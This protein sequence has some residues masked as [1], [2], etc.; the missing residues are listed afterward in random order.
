M[1]DT[2]PAQPARQPVENMPGMAQR[3]SLTY[4][5]QEVVIRKLDMN[6]ITQDQ[7]LHTL[8]GRDLSE[9]ANTYAKSVNDASDAAQV[10]DAQLDQVALM[11]QIQR[12]MLRESL[13]APTL[14]ELVAVYGGRMDSPDLGMGPDYSQLMAAVDAFQNAGDGEARKEAARTFPEA[15][16]DVAAH[17]GEGLRAATE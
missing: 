1:T 6:A 11:Q 17:A 8:R 16:G 10:M 9:V 4:S 14:E 13:V 15:V 7:V 2:K 3:V 12:G 5:Q